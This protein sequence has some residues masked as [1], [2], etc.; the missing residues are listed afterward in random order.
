VGQRNKQIS[1]TP[2]AM[3]RL[4]SDRRFP[5]AIA[6]KYLRTGKRLSA[7]RMV[8]R[9]KRGRFF[10]FQA[11]VFVSIPLQ[12]MSR[13]SLENTAL[14]GK[15]AVPP[16]VFMKWLAVPGRRESIGDR[17]MQHLFF[18]R[19]E[20]AAALPKVGHGMTP[21]G[22]LTSIYAA[23]IGQRLFLSGRSPGVSD[24]RAIAA[25][26]REDASSG[27]ERSVFSFPMPFLRSFYGTFLERIAGRRRFVKEGTNIGHMTSPVARTEPPANQAAFKQGPKTFPGKSQVQEPFF[28]STKKI[29]HEIEELKRVVRR[30]ENRIHEKVVRQLREIGAERN[31]QVDVGQ[32]THQVYRNMERMIRTE[33][34]R[35]GM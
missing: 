11:H 35:R 23:G 30:T 4:C 25:T 7:P 28:Q 19:R 22:S 29:E 26:P 13:Y 9:G 14:S 21:P 27:F 32:I 10:S 33:R 20:Y 34:E 3:I 2:G 8:F 5:E 16:P 6:A 31:L 24:G 17:V 18:M 15:E 1:V 12:M